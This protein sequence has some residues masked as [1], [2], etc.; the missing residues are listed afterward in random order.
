LGGCEGRGVGAW[1]HGASLG[2]VACEGEGGAGD[3]VAEDAAGLIVGPVGE[4]EGG[5]A[6]A[7]GG[8]EGDCEGFGGGKGHIGT[9]LA[10]CSF[11]GGRDERVAL[12]GGAGGGECGEG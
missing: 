11:V 10:D 8:V 4:V 1:G 5:A 2:D 3:A 6:D 12:V 9:C 7:V